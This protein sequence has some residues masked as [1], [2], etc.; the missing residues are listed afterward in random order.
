M[1]KAMQVASERRL[2]FV[3]LDRPNPIG[4]VDVSGPILSKGVQSF[5]NHHPLPVRHGMTIGELALLFDADLHL[6]TR[7]EIVRMQGWRRSQLYDA[8]GLPWVDPS[9]NLR[10]TTEMLLYPGVGLLEATNVSVGRGT[11]SPFE[12]MGA[13]WI[14]GDT[15]AA[16]LSALAIP[17]VTFTATTFT[18][19]ASPHKGQACGGVRI[20]IANPSEF[21]PVRVGLALATQLHALY[22]KDW[23]ESDVSRML[24]F[25]AAESALKEGK[26]VADIEATWAAELAAFKAKR[27]KYLLYGCR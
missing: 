6:G 9:P 27:E 14:N 2:R 8:T 20:G 12:V 11:D 4:G 16:A 18:P 19:A 13:P 26:S 10:S 22:A 15:L 24:A 7:L 5:V 23:H 17:G 3:V 1:R 25:P 21:E